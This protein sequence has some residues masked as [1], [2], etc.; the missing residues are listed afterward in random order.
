VPRLRLNPHSSPFLFDLHDGLLN[1]SLP[2]HADREEVPDGRFTCPMKSVHAF[3]QKAEAHC[4]KQVFEEDGAKMKREAVKDLVREHLTLRKMKESV[5]K[6]LRRIE[7]RYEEVGDLLYGYRSKSFIRSVLFCLDDLKVEYEKDE[8]YHDL[9]GS[10]IGIFT[11][12]EEYDADRRNY[13]PRE[14]L[15]LYDEEVE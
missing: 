9:R 2:R 12:F 10:L 13:T 11:G 5:Q 1:S 14:L 8:H 6:E 15:H 7:D 4:L 3:R